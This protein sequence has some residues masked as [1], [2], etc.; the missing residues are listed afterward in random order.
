[1]IINSHFLVPRVIFNW[2]GLLQLLFW[3]KF[4]GQKPRY[5]FKQYMQT[6]NKS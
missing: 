5:Y 2:D 6:S 4:M 1:M 3:L